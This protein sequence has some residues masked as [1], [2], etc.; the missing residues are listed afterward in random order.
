M[1]LGKKFVKISKVQTYKKLVM[2]YWL[3]IHRLYVVRTTKDGDV[4]EENRVQID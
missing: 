1:K 3:Y 4:R 2:N